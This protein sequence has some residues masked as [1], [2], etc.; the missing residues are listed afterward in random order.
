MAAAIGLLEL[1]SIPVGVETAD[2][3]LKSADVKLLQASPSCPGKYIIVITGDVGV[4]RSAME[5]GSHAAGQ[6][7]LAEY[8]ISSVHHTVPGAIVGTADTGRIDAIGMVETISALTAI[9]AGDIAAKAAD[10]RL[11]EIRV[12]RGLGGKGFVLMTGDIAAVKAAINA[13]SDQLADSGEI[14]SF[15]TIPSPH[16][17][18]IEHI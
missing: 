5:T 7:L 8:L 4:V 10:V 9:Q 16:P 14:T 1:K 2:A 11:L 15:C 17:D 6:Y 12:A 18:L 13:V 3:V